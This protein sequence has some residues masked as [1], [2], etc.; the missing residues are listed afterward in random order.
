MKAFLAAVGEDVDDEVD[1]SFAITP[2]TQLEQEELN[3]LMAIV[4]ASPTPKLLTEPTLVEM[5]EDP[6][7][8]ELVDQARN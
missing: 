6:Y 7:F 8:Q 3:Q 5:K 1:D 2:L 4:K